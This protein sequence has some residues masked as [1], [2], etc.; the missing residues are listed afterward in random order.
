MKKK[1]NSFYESGLKNI[2]NSQFLQKQRSMLYTSTKC[3]NFYIYYNVPVSKMYDNIGTGTQST[4]TG[5]F[6]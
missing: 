5:M 1:I 4:G 6:S 2:L 3:S